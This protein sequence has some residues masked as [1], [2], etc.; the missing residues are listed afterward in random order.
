MPRQLPKSWLRRDLR[1]SVSDGAAYSIMV[2][3]GE[4]YLPAFVLALGLGQVRSGLTA[5]VPMLIGAVLQMAGPVL[6]RSLGSY[7]RW[8]VLCASLQ[9]LGFVPLCLA[10][11]FQWISWT[12]VVA[13][14]ALYWGAGLASGP[15][16]NTWM[17]RLVRRPIRATFFAWRTRICQAAVLL[18]LLG[19]GAVL[20]WASGEGWTL[21]G[22]AVV[23]AG[24]CGF[25]VI[26]AVFIARQR[27]PAIQPV[28]GDAPVSLK[29]IVARF[30]RSDGRLLVYML[31]VQTATHLA[32]PYFTPFMLKQ[33]QLPYLSYVS[34]LAVAFLAKIA[35]LPMAGR[36]AH[37]LGARRLLWLGGSGIVPLAVL[38]NV[39]DSVPYLMSI[40]V[41]GGVA[42]GC[43]ELATFLLL[44]E[45]IPDHERTS[46]LTSFNLANAA[47]VA[48]GSIVGGWLL[49]AL[50]GDRAAYLVLFAVSSGARALSLPLLTRV[51]DL[52]RLPEWIALRPLAVRPSAGSIDRPILSTMQGT[53][54][55]AEGAIPTTE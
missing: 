36:L 9:A 47:A 45:A 26:S 16:W 13:A 20:E 7:R 41:L 18:G 53:G 3:A 27:E 23:F 14:A 35:V 46:V 42:W 17:G 1:A 49:T 19:A 5:T 52:P 55:S 50:G 2:G 43:Y 28:W 12:V 22:F 30:G 15:A 25:R 37:R 48:I 4:T 39:S 44:F 31:M 33:L 34:L 24:A 21:A 29:A 32:A 10:A 6:I 40:Q 8:V 11:W 54:P 51:V 38:W